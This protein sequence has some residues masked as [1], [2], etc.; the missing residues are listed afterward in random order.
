VER[1]RRGQVKYQENE[2][3]NIIPNEINQIFS[4]IQKKNKSGHIVEKLFKKFPH[5]EGFSPKRFYL[6][7]SLLKGR[8]GH[9]T[10]EKSLKLCESWSESEQRYYNKICRV[11]IHH[12][13]HED[14]IFIILTSKRMKSD[15]KFDHLRARRQVSDSV[16]RILKGY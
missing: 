11:L 6:Y 1:K 14:S 16:L 5:G 9:Y 13:L 15:K 12:F 3:R 4:F 10:N 2:N 8:L 7:Q